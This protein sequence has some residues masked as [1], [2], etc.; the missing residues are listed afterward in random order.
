MLEYCDSLYQN[1]WFLVR[2]KSSKYKLVNATMEINK[3]TVQDTNLPLLV[4]EFS[5]E[6][7]G[8]QMA[9]MIDFFF[10]YDQIEL[11][12]KSRDLIGFQTLIRLL[13]IT[14]LP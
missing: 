4:N 11:N 5:E 13:R 12:T 7:A 8:C 14:T 1:P 10:G 9:L 2:K 3:H 6:F